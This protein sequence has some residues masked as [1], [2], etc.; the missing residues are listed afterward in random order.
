[1]VE[2]PRWMV[3]GATFTMLKSSWSTNCAE[4]NNAKDRER[5]LAG[6][7]SVAVGSPRQPLYG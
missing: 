1:M 5:R 2:N 7:L 4:H 3:V 6:S